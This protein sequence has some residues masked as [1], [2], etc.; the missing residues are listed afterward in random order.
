MRGLVGDPLLV[1]YARG[2]KPTPRAEVLAAA[3]APALAALRTS[4]APQRGLDPKCVKRAVVI[5]S[6]DYIDLTL[7]PSVTARL[8]QE[9][10][11][12]DLRIRA[13]SRAS[14]VQDLRRHE[15]DLAIGPLAAAP[16]AV[17]LTP[18]FE[19]R[20]VM[21]SRRGHPGLRKRLSP[22]RFAALH[23]LLVSP[24]G[25][26]S[27]VVDQALRELGLA[28]RIVVTVPHFLAAPIIV[29]ST[30]LVAVVPERVA[31]RM[32]SAADIEV[33]DV[34]VDIPGWTV[35]LARPKNNVADSF[36]TWLVQLIHDVSAELGGGSSRPRRPGAATQSTLDNR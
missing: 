21:I 19:E 14:V 20:F 4:V 10:P 7:M 1:K 13:T 2:V 24:R 36:M 23:H 32:R 27:G 17:D 9:A 16:D 15:I 8:Q 31:R 34:P 22:P 33:R 25:D 29:A 6:S 11:S 18:L 3:I 12:I 30:D 28:R 5:G 26:P 35:G